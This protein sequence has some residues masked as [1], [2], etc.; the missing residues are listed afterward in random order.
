MQ[1]SPIRFA[2][3]I[4]IYVCNCLQFCKFLQCGQKFWNECQFNRPTK[5]YICLKDLANLFIT[6]AQRINL[7]FKSEIMKFLMKFEDMKITYVYLRMS[8]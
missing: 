3:L 6:Y 7:I 4:I 5:L 2:I 1:V 8:M